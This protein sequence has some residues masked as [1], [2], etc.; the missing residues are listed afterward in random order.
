[1][2]ERQRGVY[3]GRSSNWDDGTP[4]LKNAVSDAYEVAKNRRLENDGGDGE[5]QEFEFRVVDIRV[6]GTN[7]IS[8]YVVDITDV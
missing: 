7:P 6:I 4:S 1:M 5:G 2:P 3:T 8:D